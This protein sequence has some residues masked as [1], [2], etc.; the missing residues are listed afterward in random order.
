MKFSHPAA[1]EI[2]DKWIAAAGLSGFKAVTETYRAARDPK[3]PNLVLVFDQI[4]TPVRAEGTRWF[5]RD[6]MIAILQG[7]VSGAELPAVNVH[8]LPGHTPRPFALRDGFHRFYASAAAGFGAVP[9]A[10][11]PYFDIMSC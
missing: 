11:L 10:V 7:I 1:F 5:D 3:W 2:P 8:E 4:V 9:V 6:R